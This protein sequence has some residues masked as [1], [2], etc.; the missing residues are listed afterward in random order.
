MDNFAMSDSDSELRQIGRR[1]F[2]KQ[3]TLVLTTAATGVVGCSKQ[4]GGISAPNEFAEAPTGTEEPPKL[5]RIGLMTDLH[6]ADKPEFGSRFYRETVDKIEEAATEFLISRID[7]AVELG[8]LIDAADSV[9]TELG[10]LKTINDKFST[11][12]KDRHYVLGNHC[13]DML[14]K[15]EFLGTVEQKESYYSFDRNGFH[16]IVLDACFRNDSEP[17]GRK[18]SSWADSNIPPKEIEWLR[19]DLKATRKKVVVFVHQRLDTD[20]NFGIKNAPEIRQILEAS[21]NV[22]A[23]FQGHSHE[24]DLN[25]IGGIHYCTLRAMV[26][27]SGADHNS[28]SVLEMSPSGIIKVKG[29][30]MQSEYTW[31]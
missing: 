29:F 28:Y 22:L 4:S 10:Y 31:V 20:S 2:L 25:D 17:Y 19:G 8:D 14:T 21:G 6:H 1:A 9:D 26:E 15:A 7:F 27:G 11:I 16:F 24:N 23:V 5:I 3:G 12:A 30:R 18:N 13:V